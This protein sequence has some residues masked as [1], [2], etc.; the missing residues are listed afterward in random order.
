MWKTASEPAVSNVPIRSGIVSRMRY[1]VMN[2]PPPPRRSF[3]PFGSIVGHDESSKR[4]SPAFGCRSYDTFHGAA[5]GRGGPSTILAS[6]LRQLPAKTAAPSVVIRSTM[7]A[8]GGPVGTNL[9]RGAGVGP[10]VPGGGVAVGPGISWAY[11]VRANPNGTI[12]PATARTR[13]V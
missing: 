3:S 2:T 9:G 13:P 7:F 12:V 4:A 1:H 8:G 5:L 6:M 10:E 11:I